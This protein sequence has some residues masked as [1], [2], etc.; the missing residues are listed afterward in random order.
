MSPL[1]SE[2]ARYVSADGTEKQKLLNDY[3]DALE[4]LDNKINGGARDGGK[5][6]NYEL[7]KKYKVDGYSLGDLSKKYGLLPANISMKIFRAG[8]EMQKY[9]NNIF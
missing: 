2:I 5:S 7:Y 3:N 1:C 9:K 6:Q 4:Y 8:K